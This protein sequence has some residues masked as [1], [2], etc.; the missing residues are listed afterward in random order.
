MEMHVNVSVFPHLLWR[1]QLA[2]ASHVR[3]RGLRGKPSAGSEAK[4][5]R[6]VLSFLV[7]KLLFLGH[8]FEPA[9]RAQRGRN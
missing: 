6:A 8:D 1:G 4:R 2:P 3:P 7:R 5:E 9:N